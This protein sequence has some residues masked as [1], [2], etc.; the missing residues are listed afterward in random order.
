MHTW[1]TEW[2]TG[3]IVDFVYEKDG[4]IYI[5]DIKTGKSIYPINFIQTS[6]YGKM[7]I[8]NKVIDKV[9]GMT[10]LLLSKDGSFQTQN[11]Y[12]FDGNVKC[13]EAC[14]LMYRHL[15]SISK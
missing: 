6:A 12:D 11:N 15:E 9:D 5:G 2:W 3:G 10:I 14:L 4:K 13:F 7:L 1:S 8:E